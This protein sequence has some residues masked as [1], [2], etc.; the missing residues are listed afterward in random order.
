MLFSSEN[1]YHINA[2][3]SL[4]VETT[5]IFFYITYTKPTCIKK[6]QYMDL[7]LIYNYR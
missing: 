7:N 3:Q 6:P 2:T 4:N 1:Y 5:Y